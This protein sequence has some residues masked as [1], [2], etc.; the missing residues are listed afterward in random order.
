[1]MYL[2]KWSF[3]ARRWWTGERLSNGYV[4]NVLYFNTW[5]E[6]IDN[7]AERIL[8]ERAEA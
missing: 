2:V 1:M 8:L 3:H 4:D 7:M 6:A 5:R